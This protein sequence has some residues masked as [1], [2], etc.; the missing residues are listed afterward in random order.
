VLNE[1]D[2]GEDTYAATLHAWQRRQQ[3]VSAE[4][5]TK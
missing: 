2:R 4:V 1:L 3:T 5:Q